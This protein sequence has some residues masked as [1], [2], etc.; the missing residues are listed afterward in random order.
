[1]NSCLQLLLNTGEGV[2]LGVGVQDEGFRRGI[3]I[4]GV[5][6]VGYKKGGGGRVIRRG[7]LL[8]VANVKKI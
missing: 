8:A 4:R 3:E 5:Q 6:E 1:M 7:G 2:S